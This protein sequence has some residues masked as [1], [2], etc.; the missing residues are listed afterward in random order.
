MA[1]R[2]KKDIRDRF[3]RRVQARKNAEFMANPPTTGTASMFWDASATMAPTRDGVLVGYD[4]RL[5]VGSS[6]PT[7]TEMIWP[8]PVPAADSEVR[9]SIYCTH[10][11]PVTAVVSPPLVPLVGDTATDRESDRRARVTALRS[12]P[13]TSPTVPMLVIPIGP[14]THHVCMDC[15]GHMRAGTSYPRVAVI[16]HP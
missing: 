11:V 7:Q 2:V 16:R 13:R 1:A 14:V 9:K 8:K 4:V 3:N 15:L 12:A 5:L 10:Y 6:E